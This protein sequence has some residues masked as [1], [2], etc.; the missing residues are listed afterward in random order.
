MPAFKDGFLEFS[1]QKEALVKL[2]FGDGMGLLFISQ[3]GWLEEVTLLTDMKRSEEFRAEEDW[4]TLL[5]PQL[6]RIESFSGAGTQMP[7]VCLVVV[8]EAAETGAEGPI[9]EPRTWVGLSALLGAAVQGEQWAAWPCVELAMRIGATLAQRIKQCHRGKPGKVETENRCSGWLWSW[10]TSQ[11]MAQFAQMWLLQWGNKTFSSHSRLQM[12][13][14]DCVACFELYKYWANFSPFWD[15]LE[16][17]V[18]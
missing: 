4:C 13:G 9:R 12:T 6:R 2:S 11:L 1:L 7:C 10:G 8:L 3:P 17:C 5:P 16:Q 14:W 18:K 15:I